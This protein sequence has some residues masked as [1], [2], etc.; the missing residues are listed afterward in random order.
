MYNIIQQ[1]TNDKFLLV[2]LFVALYTSY[3]QKN[4][5]CLQ[6]SYLQI[7]SNYNVLYGLNNG[8]VPGLEMAWF[9]L[10]CLRLY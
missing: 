1:I 3:I 4:I 5:L 2:L 7:S 6:E 10:H 8:C 9:V